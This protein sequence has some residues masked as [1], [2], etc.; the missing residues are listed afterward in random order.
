MSDN[1]QQIAYWNEV[2]G[3]KWVRIQGGMEARLIGVE[4][5]LLARARPQA[6]E[7]VLEIGCGTGTTTA[8]LADAVG[9]S[10][11][12]TAVDVARPMLDVAQV[13]LAAQ[14]NV[15]L[16]EADA[17]VT[18]FEGNFDLLTSRFGI[19]FFQNPV[20]AFRNL[21]QALRP[22]GRLVCVAWAPLA[23]NQHWLVP[24]SLV[25]A[26][27]G[28]GKPRKPHAPGPLA[29]DDA[30]YVTSIL[31]E[32][33]FADVTVRAEPVTLIGKSLDDEAQVA[34][35]MGPAG[36]LLDEKAAEP[37]VR[38]ELTAAFRTALPDYADKAARMRAT[39]H[40][41]TARHRL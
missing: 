18:K 21:H 16:T 13:R 23:D 24:L 31:T 20:A 40:I 11:H 35:T 4:D 9:P 3:P 33:G 27:L 36:A 6:G 8:R 2:A 22:G 39:V 5:L 10:G 41:I 29:F 28:A 12:V 17:A 26:R 7:H 37:A 38:A 14:H 19:M 34:A 32:A 25:T 15:T 30:D 1:A